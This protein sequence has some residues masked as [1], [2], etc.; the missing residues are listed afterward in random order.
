M[1]Y[2]DLRVSSEFI[3]VAGLVRRQVALTDRMSLASLACSSCYPVMSLGVRAR[4]LHSHLISP[5][6]SDW[7]ELT[8][9]AQGAGPTSY[10]VWVA[11]RT[12][13]AAVS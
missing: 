1:S 5:A 13:E 3:A 11:V 2:L 7:G 10:D 4:K 12:M 9:R 8:S 6:S